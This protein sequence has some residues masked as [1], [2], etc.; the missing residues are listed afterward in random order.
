MRHKPNAQADRASVAPRLHARIVHAAEVHRFIRRY[1]AKISRLYAK[2]STA[3]CNR[4][5]KLKLTLQFNIIYFI[6]FNCNSTCHPTTKIDRKNSKIK[7]APL[8][9]HHLQIALLRLLR[10]PNLR[11]KWIS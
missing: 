7:Y 1:Y 5:V 4:Q 11:S 8:I 3:K 10:F 9:Y 2:T 6:V